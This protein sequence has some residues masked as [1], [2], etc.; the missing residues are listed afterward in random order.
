MRTS[1]DY[2]LHGCGGSPSRYRDRAPSKSKAGARKSSSARPGYERPTRSLLPRGKSDRVGSARS[3]ARSS[4]RQLSI[5]S[6][7][8]CSEMGFH[9]SHA[10]GSRC[11]ARKRISP[12]RGISTDRGLVHLVDRRKQDRR[13]LARVVRFVSQPWTSTR[14]GDELLAAFGGPAH[15]SSSRLASQTRVA[16]GTWLNL[17][18][19]FGHAAARPN[20]WSAS[21]ALLRS[22]GGVRALLRLV[23]ELWLFRN[24]G[25]PLY[26]PKTYLFRGDAEARAI[27]GSAN[28]TESALWINYEDAAVIEFDLANADEAAMVAEL[29]R[30]S[31]E[32][33]STPN[34][35]RATEELVTQLEEAG[36]LPSEAQR[37][38]RRHRDDTERDRE[39][40]KI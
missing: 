9:R 16:S 28:L 37:R 34:A 35:R 5:R 7:C 26:H 39:A 38:Q 27:V 3:R 8:L 40:A 33:I 11:S 10:M 19:S 12:T 15:G 20:S 32:P 23:D 17:S 6:S 25:C 36:L 4:A 13:A 24:P 30:S 14:I 21:T 18:W 31:G 29:E 1:T 22:A 2:P